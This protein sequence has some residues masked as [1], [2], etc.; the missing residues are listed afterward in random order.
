MPKTVSSGAISIPGV[1]TPFTAN[2]LP[3]AFDA[4]DFEYRPRLQLLPDALDQR[5]TRDERFVVFH[6]GKSRAGHAVAAVINTLLVQMGHLARMDRN[7]EN[8][9][10]KAPPSE[11]V[12][13]HTLRHLARRY[14]RFQGTEDSGLSLRA[15][16][17]GWFHHG[18]TL[19]NI[20]PAAEMDEEPSQN[21]QDWFRANGADRPLGAY[22]RINPL[23]LDDVRAA[24]GELHAV[25]ASATIHTGWRNPRR[26]TNPQTGEEMYLIRRELDAE[27]LGGH[28]FA[29]VGYNKEGFL[30]QNS[31]GPTWGKEGYATLSYE[32][33]L[34]SAYDA[35]VGRPSVPQTAFASGRTRELLAAGNEFV[36]AAALD[37]R[38]L[39]VHTVTLDNDGLLFPGAKIPST[40]AHIEGI[41]TR[42]EQWHDQWLSQQV[43][44]KRHIVLYAHG[45]L[46]DENR[47]LTTAQNQLNW[48]LNNHIYPIFFIWRSGIFETLFNVVRDLWPE[49]DSSELSAFTLTDPIDRGVESLVRQNGRWVWDEMKENAERASKRITKPEQI[50]WPPNTLQ[51]HQAMSR[52]P[53]AS[54]T[55]SRLAKYVEDHENVVIH[56]VGHSAGTIFHTELLA[57]L[58]AAEVQVET[59]SFLAAGLRVDR[60]LKDVHPYIGSDRTVKRFTNFALTNQQEEDDNCRVEPLPVPFYHKSLLYLVSRG[61][62][63]PK[64]GQRKPVP[65]LGM[66]RFF[67]EPLQQK[68]TQVGGTAIFSRPAN[69]SPPLPSPDSDCTATQHG[70]FAADPATMLSV[71]LR[72]LGLAEA[73]ERNIFD[74]DGV[75]LI[76]QEP[77]SLDSGQTL[78]L[79]EDGAQAQPLVAP[80]MDGNQVI[81]EVAVAPRSGS[82]IVDMLMADGWVE[83]DT[84]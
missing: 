43:I 49:S 4:R 33:W 21:G 75:A 76:D 31:W 17:K 68:I 29:I 44:D 48:W 32:D 78:S 38:R 53:G 80:P 62:E 10:S 14:A 79:A 20:W 30:V 40:P 72:A 67:D 42:M 39:G 41:F 8:G 70:G 24:I 65:L 2:V 35:W 54:L 66:A 46:V 34:D 45:G 26:M 1:S 11:P 64:S 27:P 18:I 16:F 63:R 74:P 19:D 57:P 37:T 61:L 56:L 9:Q 36:T 28:A 13:P 77:P 7:R 52:M 84:P 73:T 25:A 50:Q 55:V 51:A 3:D 83:T 22:Y 60:F 59:M 5:G 15:V 12:T 69:S 82:P 71:L 47:G 6:N 58:R 23:R 81:P